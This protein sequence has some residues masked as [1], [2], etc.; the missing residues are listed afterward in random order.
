VSIHI[1]VTKNTRVAIWLRSKDANSSFFFGVAGENEVAHLCK[2]ESGGRQGGL[3]LGAQ[4][5]QQVDFWYSRSVPGKFRNGIPLLIVCALS[6]AFASSGAGR[7]GV[8]VSQQ[9]TQQPPAQPQQIPEQAVAPAPRPSLNVVVLDP[10]HGGSDL[11]ARGSSGINE[12]D[13]VLEFARALHA[14]LEAQGFRVVQTRTGNEDPSFDDRSMTANAQRGAIF[15]TLHVS[16]T[17][18]PGQVRVYSE[19]LTSTASAASTISASDAAAGV[20][21]QTPSALSFPLRNGLLPWDRAQE[22]YAAASR[23]L[24][25]LAQTPLTQ[26]FGGSPASPT[27]AA[28]RQLRTVATPA[29]AIEISSVSVSNREQ[30]LKMTAG[31]ADG[32]AQAVAAFRAIY[33]ASGR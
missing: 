1:D 9:T 32:V 29:I 13:I 10:A 33:E 5:R 30:L 11:G 6:A 20:P 17:G 19:P 22:P 14:A 2:L 28:V 7:V 25:E 31:L 4:L 8:R 23:R 12:S 24:A 26:K 3:T 16:S 18:T 21:V 15:I 27:F